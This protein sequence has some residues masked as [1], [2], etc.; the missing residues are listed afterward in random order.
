MQGFQTALDSLLQVK[1]LAGGIELHVKLTDPLV[2]AVIGKEIVAAGEEPAEERRRLGGV[3]G[4]LVIGAGEAEALGQFLD[5]LVGHRPLYTS[6]SNSSMI[7][8]STM[9]MWS[10]PGVRLPS[11][12]RCPYS[13]R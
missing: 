13:S 12:L 7:C 6:F 11:R 2:V 3:L 9:A 5:L 10:R 1:S 4:E 8:S